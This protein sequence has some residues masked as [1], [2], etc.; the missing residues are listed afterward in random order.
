MIYME[1]NVLAAA[2]CFTMACILKGP[3]F[4]GFKV[5]HMDITV[6]FNG[7]VMSMVNASGCLGGF[8]SPLIVSNV[9]PNNKLVEWK[10]VGWIIWIIAFIFTTYYLFAAQATRAEWDV[11]PDEMEDYK[12]EKA[13]AAALAQERKALKKQKK[14][15]KK[16]K[17]AASAS[18]Q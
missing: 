14:D 6:N 12:K 15:A 10:R 11:P 18:T 5:N 13:A 16:G 3:H 2:L 1:C 8:I 7:I 4:A 17:G 9:A